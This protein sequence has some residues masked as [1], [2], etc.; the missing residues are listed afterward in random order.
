MRPTAPIVLAAKV[1][2]L[3]CIG[4]TLYC[5]AVYLLLQLHPHTPHTTARLG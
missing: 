4:L 5:S 3:G 1:F 2:V